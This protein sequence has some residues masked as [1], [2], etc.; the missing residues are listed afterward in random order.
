[1]LTLWSEVC[2]ELHNYGYIPCY[3]STH[4]PL[5]THIHVGR[6]LTLRLI[7]NT[8]QCQGLEELKPVEQNLQYDFN[9]QHASIF[10]EEVTVYP[11]RS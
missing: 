3:H 2:S 11:V 6:G 5:L 7:H 9:S 10:P 8:T 4:C 1:M